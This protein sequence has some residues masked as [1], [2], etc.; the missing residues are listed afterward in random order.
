MIR[1]D[2]IRRALTEIAMKSSASYADKRPLSERMIELADSGHAK[3]D[4]LRARAAEFDEATRAAYSEDPPVDA[5]KLL[6][7]A[8]ARARRVWCACTGEPLFPGL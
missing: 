3:A 4:E 5:V 8:W 1:H 7:K 6:V 2:P